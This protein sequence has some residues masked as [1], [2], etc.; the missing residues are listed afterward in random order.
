MR[1]LDSREAAADKD[2]A[3]VLD[4][5]AEW[6]A[7]HKW[8]QTLIRYNRMI[9]GDQ[10]HIT[11]MDRVR[12]KTSSPDKAE[13]GVDSTRIFSDH[14]ANII[15]TARV[16]IRTFKGGKVEAPADPTKVGKAEGRVDSTRVFRVEVKDHA[17]R[18]LDAGI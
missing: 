14:E 3:V 4:G 9:P 12:T 16:R 11:R 13:A 6:P 1:R 18:D 8:T 10:G 5:D 2:G 17:V 15:R 7:D